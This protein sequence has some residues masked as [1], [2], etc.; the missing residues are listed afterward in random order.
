MDVLR[1]LGGMVNCGLIIRNTSIG[2]I[3]ESRLQLTLSV[4][5]EFSKMMA[6][7]FRTDCV[8]RIVSAKEPKTTGLVV[9]LLHPGEKCIFKRLLRNL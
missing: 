4:E 2:N 8:V 5:T 9:C 3:D 6:L 7:L 1:E